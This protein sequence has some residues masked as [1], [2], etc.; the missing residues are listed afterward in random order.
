MK[1]L[2]LIIIC[3]FCAQTKAQEEITVVTLTD[4]IGVNYSIE[5][6]HSLGF[7]KTNEGELL[8]VESQRKVLLTPVEENTNTY[9]LTE[10]IR[11]LDVARM[12]AQDFIAE[13]ENKNE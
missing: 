3:L 11:N 13:Y 5:E 8:L 7:Q 9:V 6:I 10:V 2:F 4:S 1:N 12:L